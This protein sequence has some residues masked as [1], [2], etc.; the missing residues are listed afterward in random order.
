MPTII[1]EESVSTSANRRVTVRYHSGLHASCEPLAARGKSG[2]DW[3]ASVKDVSR[4]GLGLLLD[5]RFE[6]GTI[7]TVDL[8]LDPHSNCMILARVAHCTP[9]PE[10]GWLVGCELLDRDAGEELVRTWE[11][12]R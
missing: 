12:A 4:G 1:A 11:K 8:T 3:R 10:G 5:R 7:L 9:Q 2:L 6:V